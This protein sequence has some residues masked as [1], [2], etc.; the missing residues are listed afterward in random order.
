MGLIRLIIKLY[1]F[2]IIIDAVLSY[3]PNLRN[4]PIVH[5]IKRLADL[6][7]KPVRKVLPPE[8]PIDVSPLIVIILLNIF[9]AI[10]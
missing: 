3:F 9:M 6:T 2:V 5:N 1:I 10:W 8:L 7:L 4:H